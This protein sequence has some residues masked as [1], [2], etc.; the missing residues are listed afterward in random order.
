MTNDFDRTQVERTRYAVIAAT[1][2]SFAGEM[3]EDGT[4][5]GF[6]DPHL[7]VQ[8]LIEV[9]TAMMA[10]SGEFAARKDRREF[11]EVVRKRVLIAFDAF[12]DQ[13]GLLDSVF[14][15][16]DPRNPSAGL[17]GMPGPVQ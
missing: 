9:L 7:A 8:V 2:A 14:E 5:G 11:A 10:K 17:P 16:V 15:P 13:P 6:L 4:V 3:T 1:I 12:I